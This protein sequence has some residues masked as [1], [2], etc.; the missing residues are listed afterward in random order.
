MELQAFSNSRRLPE[1]GSDRR[2]LQVEARAATRPAM[3]LDGATMLLNDT[4]CDRQAEARPFV[5][6]LGGEE[7]IVNAVDMLGIDAVSAVD[8]VDLDTAVR[9]NR[10]VYLQHSVRAHSVAR[11]DEQI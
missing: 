1:L 2:K 5:R 8:H 11:V 10:G 4:V 9:L 6:S 3:D 7:R